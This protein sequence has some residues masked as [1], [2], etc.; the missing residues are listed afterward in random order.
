MS[1]VAQLRGKES[2][3]YLAEI[4][5]GYRNVSDEE[6]LVVKHKCMDFISWLIRK[7]HTA[8][9]AQQVCENI[10]NSN[11]KLLTAEDP[12]ADF[13][14]SRGDEVGETEINIL[15]S[16]D[17]SV[18]KF[19]EQSNIECN[20]HHSM[21]DNI[22][23]TAERNMNGYDFRYWARVQETIQPIVD[24]LDIYDKKDKLSGAEKAS[25]RKIKRTV[26]ELR[27]GKIIS[28]K[29]KT[30]QIRSVNKDGIYIPVNTWK[31]L[32][33]RINKLLRID[34]QYPIKQYEKFTSEDAL[35]NSVSL[36]EE[37]V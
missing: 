35:D 30:K 37:Y 12:Y 18:E 28:W 31:M 36:E 24:K 27:F 20:L 34:K 25:L 5:A 4:K 23:K 7:G 32:T 2:F 26:N 14:W 33:N 13:V 22:Q 29:N 21:W 11:L 19:E 9:S 15:T 1:E 17:P 6:L 10:Y 8:D 16:L 3:I